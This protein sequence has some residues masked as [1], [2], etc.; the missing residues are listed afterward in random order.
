MLTD[1][2]DQPQL[3]AV[4]ALVTATVPDLT[5]FVV[6]ARRGLEATGIA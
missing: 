6:R 2:V 5:G 4:G 1:T 3:L